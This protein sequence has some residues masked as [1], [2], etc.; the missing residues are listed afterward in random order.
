MKKKR[1]KVYKP[2]CPNKIGASAQAAINRPIT[3]AIIALRLG[4]AE[5]E[6]YHDLAASMMI[7]YQAAE[8]T[9]RH[10]HLLPD[11]QL[12]LDA[13]GAIW[14]RHEQRTVRDAFYSGTTQEVDALDNAAQIYAALIQTT[15]GKTMR[16]AISRVQIAARSMP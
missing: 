11:L 5:A 16:S 3:N 13:L 6:S 14:A 8:L 1:N 4:Y 12:A 15:S 2:I 10:R 7:A 9:D